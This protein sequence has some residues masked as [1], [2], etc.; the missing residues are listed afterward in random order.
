VS[1]LTSWQRIQAALKGEEADRVPF[2]L[3]VTMHGARAVGVPLRRYFTRVDDVVEGQ[4][5]L[6]ARLG[7]D[8]VTPF[9]YASLE[10]EAFGGESIVYDDGPPNA[11]EPPLRGA[12]DVMALQPP[13]PEDAPGLRRTLEVTRRLAARVEGACPV[14][15]AVISPFSL[16]AMQLGLPAWFELLHEQPEVAERLLRVNEAFTVAWAN[17]LAAAGA[18]PILFFDPV[19]SP[20]QVPAALYQRLA[21]PSMR[22]CLAAIRAPVIM[23]YASSR[24]LAR[25]QDA[26]AAGAI[27]V[28]GSPLEPLPALKAACGDQLLLVGGLDSVS[29]VSATPAQAAATARAAIQA[30]GRGG[31]FLLCEHHGEIPWQVPEEVLDAVAAAV[32]E[33]GRYPLAPQ[34]GADG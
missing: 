22:R 21:L 13:R 11:G 19:A 29:L 10:V 26:A 3:P 7:H 17:A 8:L 23:G 16:P 24:G 6:R 20:D 12:A 33:H 32:H 34:A 28:T 1:A 30:I 15:A 9:M 31:R 5:R 25:V 18:A 2:F 4:L 14:L 27:A